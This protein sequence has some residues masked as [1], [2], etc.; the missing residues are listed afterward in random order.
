MKLHFFQRFKFYLINIEEFYK[1]ER[2]VQYKSSTIIN[3]L[4]ALQIDLSC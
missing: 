2:M 4:L 1:L 3:R